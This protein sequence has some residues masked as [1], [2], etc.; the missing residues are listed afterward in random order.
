MGV[1][2]P[3]FDIPDDIQTGVLSGMYRITGGVVRWSTGPN[4]GQIVKHLKT[5]DQKEVEQAKNAAQVIMNAAK[6][7]K[8]AAIV[9]TVVV[10]AASAG[11]ITYKNL[12]SREP[13]V[14][15]EFRAALRVYIDAIRAGEM[16]I[17][18]IDS[19]M[20]ALEN[21]RQNKNYEKYTIQLSAEDIGTLVCRIQEY[22][23]QLANENNLQ[24]SEAEKAMSDDVFINF[25]NYLN[26]QRRVFENAA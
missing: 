25:N 24:I 6:Q 21:L 5:I 9:G 18:V 3:V 13:K 16:T 11:A 12:K 8:K 19:M 2:Q 22:T 15:K 14:I 20:D 26:I 17:E 4:K 10:A 23:I 1:Y 7:N